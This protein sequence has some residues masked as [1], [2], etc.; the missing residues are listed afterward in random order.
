MDGVGTVTEYA[1]AKFFGPDVL[2]DWLE[3]KSYAEGA[4]IKRI[5][6]DVGKNVQVRGVDAAH[7]GLVAHPRDPSGAVYVLAHAD[8]P[9]RTVTFLGWN[10][11][12]NLKRE[13]FWE[14]KKAGFNKPG[15]AAY[16]VPQE[17]LKPMSTLPMEEV[18]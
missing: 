10:W 7:K 5:L 17:H 18:R 15:R 3:L 4:A 2:K 9:T 1:L 8:V 14:N 12:G 6:A 11:G 13:R 16:L